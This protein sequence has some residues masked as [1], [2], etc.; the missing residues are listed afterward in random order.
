M[1]KAV[2]PQTLIALEM[3]GTP[4][5]PLHGGPARALVPGFVA[6]ASMKWLERIIVQADE[7]DGF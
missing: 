5:Q 3:N 6:S 7:F 1:W 2:N 4:L